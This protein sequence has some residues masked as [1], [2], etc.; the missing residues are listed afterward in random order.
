M[1]LLGD[2]AKV[3]FWSGTN[4]QKKFLY[5]TYTAT[6]NAGN[7]WSHTE[8]IYHSLGYSPNV[9]VWVEQDANGRIHSPDPINSA[10]ES[11]IRTKTYDNRV[12]ITASSPIVSNDVALLIYYEIYLD[13]NNTGETSFDFNT[14][15]P[16]DRV[17]EIVE[18]SVASIGTGSASVTSV[19]HSVG[20]ATVHKAIWSF[21]NV[22]WYPVRDHYNTSNPTI[23]ATGEFDV[24]SSVVN[25]Y[26]ANYLGSTQTFY[27]KVA[28]IEPEVEFPAGSSPY[29]F[30]FDTRRDS[31]KNLSSVD[32]SQALTGTIS[33]GAI[34]TFTQTVGSVSGLNVADF[35]YKESTDTFYYNGYVAAGTGL[36]AVNVT[37]GAVVT[38]IP[39]EIFLEVS[40]GQTKAIMW[41]F[42]S[43]VNAVTITAKTIDLRLVMYSSPFN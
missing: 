32:V 14:E 7:S 5:D 11:Q 23:N 17:L 1:T 38:L 30:N 6:L 34:A 20:K 4:Y 18:G 10:K 22:N 42:N 43:D 15:Y 2:I 33:S 9:R 40:N 41:L 25:I 8:V 37:G 13:A 35:Y 24:T 39:V 21:D 3:N 31:F 19:S 27:Y 28:L 16:I 29:G 12:E 26:F 36:I